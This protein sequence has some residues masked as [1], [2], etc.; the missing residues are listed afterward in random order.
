MLA[1]ADIPLVET[2]DYRPERAP[3]QIGFSHHEVGVVATRHLHDKGYR[4]IAFVQN[5]AAGDFSALERRDGY[6]ETLKALGL[7]LIHI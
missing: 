6:V 3:I 4:R 1:E 5:S 2:W 7:S